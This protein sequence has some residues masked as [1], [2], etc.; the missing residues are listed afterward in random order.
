MLRRFRTGDPGWDALGEAASFPTIGLLPLRDRSREQSGRR[1]S[2]ARTPQTLRRY[3]LRPSEE[4]VFAMG[5][6][7]RSS[8]LI[9][10]RRARGSFLAKRGNWLPTM[11]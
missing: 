7:A 1:R 6:S 4:V 9:S 10:L 2:N 3:L 5:W 8:F 11:M